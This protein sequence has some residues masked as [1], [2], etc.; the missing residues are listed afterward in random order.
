LLAELPLAPTLY[1][2]C[3]PAAPG[4]HHQLLLKPRARH[5]TFA[6]QGLQPPQQTLQ[7]LQQY[8]TQPQSYSRSSCNAGM[9]AAHPAA[10]AGIDEHCTG[11]V[12]ASSMSVPNIMSSPGQGI[13]RGVDTGAG[14][15]CPP[16]VSG[17]LVVFGGVGAGG[18]WL[19]DV[20]LIVMTDSSSSSSS[21]SNRNSCSSAGG[22]CV[23]QTVPVPCTPSPHGLQAEGVQKGM[24]VPVCD[25]AACECGPAAFVVVGSFDGSSASM[26]LQRCVLT[27]SSSTAAQPAATAAVNASSTQQHAATD[28]ISKV[29]AAPQPHQ[30]ED[31]IAGKDHKAACSTGKQQQQQQLS[32]LEWA[33]SWRCTWEVLQ[34]RTRSPVGRCHHSCCWHAASRSLVVFGGYASRQGCLNDV[35]VFNLDHREWWQPEYTGNAA[36]VPRQPD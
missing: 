32:V 1:W 23:V 11:R 30:P 36:T 33:S 21:S 15:Q 9:D 4:S 22:G 31:S 6:L 25:F 35:Q 3:V 24:P 10:A 13:G 29:P 19:T 14:V 20:S 26:Q 17:C 12:S 28:G 27:F 34:P 5:A 8:L 7:A 16:E 18:G 2:Q